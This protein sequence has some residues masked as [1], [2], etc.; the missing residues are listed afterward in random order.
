MIL[1]AY[2][3]MALLLVMLGLA[4]YQDVSAHKIKNWLT[5]TAALAGV[6]L[7]FVEK[8]PAGLVMA[9]QGWL[10]PVLALMLLYR[11][12]MMGAGDIKLFAAMGS[13]MGLEFVTLCFIFSV[14]T[15]GVIAFVILI[16][17][18]AL[19]ARM[20]KIIRYFC[21]MAATGRIMPYVARGDNSSKFIFSAAIVPGAIVQLLIT[22]F[23]VKGGA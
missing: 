17:E 11:L 13:L 10:V 23:W 8:G 5:L 18:K 6:A 15:G 7:N 14:F 9:V 2:L 22:L 16:R 20:I 19:A 1:Y 4:L 3:K 12:N 21:L